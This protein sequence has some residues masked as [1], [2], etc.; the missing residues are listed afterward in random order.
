VALAGEL[1][2]AGLAACAHREAIRSVYHWQGRRCD[3]AEVR[4]TFKVLASRADAAEERLRARHP[5]DTPMIL[6]RSVLRTNPEYLAWARG[7]PERTD[8]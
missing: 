4:L 6:R 3:D 8:P 5:Y 2:D 1:V 7:R